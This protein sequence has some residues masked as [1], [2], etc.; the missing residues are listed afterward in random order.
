MTL[1]F[2]PILTDDDV[3]EWVRE[4]R[5]LASIKE[6]AEHLLDEAYAM[7]DEELDRRVMWKE[8]VRNLNRGND[9]R[10]TTARFT[11]GF[12]PYT[13]RNRYRAIV[14]K[15]GYL[16]WKFCNRKPCFRRQE[17]AFKHRVKAILQQ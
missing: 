14:E 9:I 15:V 16:V 4:Q 17:W 2:D 12:D 11:E 8:R 1:I 5:E 6:T 10:D 13:I 7:S 3:K